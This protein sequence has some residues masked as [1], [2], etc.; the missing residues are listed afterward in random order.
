MKYSILLAATLLGGSLVAAPASATNLVSNG[1]FETGNFTGWTQGGN[2]ASTGVESG[3]PFGGIYSAYFGPT[4]SA[5]YIE[6]RL[7]TKAGTRYVLSFALA[8][9]KATPNFFS[10]SINGVAIKSLTNSPA[11]AYRLEIFKFIADANGSS[12]LRFTFKHKPEQTHFHLDNVVVEEDIAV[13]PAG[14]VLEPST[15][16]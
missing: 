8:N 14:T 2:T 4:K 16:R 10:A 6:Q 12:V 7:A 5:G 3:N 1:D 11:F 15:P 13:P 9:D